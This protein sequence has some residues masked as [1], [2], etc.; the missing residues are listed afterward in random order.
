MQIWE[1]LYT[2]M[3]SAFTSANQQFAEF[4]SSIKAI[5]NQAI[6]KDATSVDL[7]FF[8]QEIVTDALAFDDF[9]KFVVAQ[10]AADNTWRLYG[11]T[12]FTMRAVMWAYFGN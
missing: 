10:A 6:Q 8:V 12:L 5:L 11:L 7:L 1:A 2:E 4:Q 9:N 3:F